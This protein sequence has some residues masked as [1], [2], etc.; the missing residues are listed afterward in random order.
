MIPPKQVS[1]DR[2]LDS[3][4][5]SPNWLDGCVGMLSALLE[6]IDSCRETLGVS[7]P[8]IAPSIVDQ[9]AAVTGQAQRLEL[10]FRDTV[11]MR[12]PAFQTSEL[13]ATLWWA[14]MAAHKAASAAGAARDKMAQNA[15][16]DAFFEIH[17]LMYDTISAVS[18]LSVAEGLIQ[19]METERTNRVRPN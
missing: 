14:G 4:F 7:L 3:I 19:R 15:W 18:L 5:A 16:E 6:D 2:Y 10:R 12:G 9:V 11:E 1:F 8:Q 13:G 17:A